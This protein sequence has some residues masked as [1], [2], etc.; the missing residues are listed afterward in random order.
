MSQ[1]PGFVNVLPAIPALL[2]H[3]AGVVVA[4]ILLVRQEKGSGSAV[5][6]LI[7]FAL[8]LFFDVANF[9]R[10]PLINLVSRRAAMG[11]GSLIATIGCCC[12]V[13]EVTAVVC[14]IIAIWRALSSP[15]GERVDE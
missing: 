10:G 1:L 5:L 6:A 11:I 14:L 12:S 13:F 9:A 8:L 7:G 3:L 2:V 15:D 4:I